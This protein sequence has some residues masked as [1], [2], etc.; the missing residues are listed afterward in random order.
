MKPL[1]TIGLAKGYLLKDSLEFFK[2]HDIESGDYSDRQ[3]IF[4]D[5]KNQ[6]RFMILRPTDVPVYVESGVVDMGITGL[7]ILREYKPEVITLKD[8]GFGRCRLVIAAATQAPLPEF[9]NGLKVATK[10]VSCAQDYFQKLGL[11]VD[12]IKLYGSVELAAITAL[13]DVVVD[14]V[15]TG[16]TLR[17]NGL[18]EVETIFESTAQ[19]IVNPVYYS[20]N[21]ALIRKLS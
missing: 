15:A 5:R 3:L 16:Q 9:A 19:L 7:D 20:L 13:S 21:Y 6:V 1:L 11:K 17:E 14:L 4:Q 18:V 8:L 10:F 2:Q 12:L